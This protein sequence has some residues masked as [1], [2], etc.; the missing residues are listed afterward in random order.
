MLHAIASSLRRLLF[1]EP[2]PT[3]EEARDQ[4]AQDEIELGEAEQDQ[5][6]VEPAE[7]EPDELFVMAPAAG[8]ESALAFGDE[9]GDLLEGLGSEPAP[10]DT[11]SALALKDATITEL[12]RNLDQLS[13]LGRELADATRWRA[14]A[15]ASLGSLSS[16]CA[17]L[18]ARLDAPRPAE[19]E[20]HEDHARAAEGVA[21]L[22]AE[23]RKREAATS[24]LEERLEKMR[25]KY[26]ERHKLAADRWREIQSLRRTRRDLE[27][28]LEHERQRWEEARGPLRAIVE[29]DA[30]PNPAARERLAELFRIDAAQEAEGA[31]PPKSR[32]SRTV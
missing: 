7:A 6:D 20:A 25:A 9:F 22:E 16:R 30:D 5:I 18:E 15:E 14:T 3:T 28:E 19:R 1:R 24:R 31:P 13:A 17:D 8:V 21:E 27:R 11:A 29:G 12:R 10:L 26:E 4:G 23:L 32:A 2:D